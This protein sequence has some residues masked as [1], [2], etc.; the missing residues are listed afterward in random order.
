M[1]CHGSTPSPP[2]VQMSTHHAMGCTFGW[3]MR[4]ELPY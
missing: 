1:V 2:S 3:P 4:F